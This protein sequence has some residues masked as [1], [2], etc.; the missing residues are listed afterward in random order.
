MTRTERIGHVTSVGRALITFRGVVWNIRE[1]AARRAR[2]IQ[3]DP[4]GEER[5]ARVTVARFSLA[6]NLKAAAVVSPLPPSPSLSPPHHPLV[7]VAPHARS[8]RERTVLGPSIDPRP[9]S[10]ERVEEVVCRWPT[11]GHGRHRRRRHCLPVCLPVC[12]LVLACLLASFLPVST[13]LPVC[14]AQEEFFIAGFPSRSKP[15]GN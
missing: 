15:A 13:R 14:A 10:R 6:W 2:G 9:H 1:G 8:S 3:L 4:K 12:L 5:R 11:T 7:V